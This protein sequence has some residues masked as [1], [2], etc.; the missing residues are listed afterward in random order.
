M[1]VGFFSVGDLCYSGWWVWD[2]G[3]LERS[4]MSPVL[5][6]NVINMYL[7]DSTLV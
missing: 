3:K 1:V 6:E 2:L 4:E 5:L 7:G